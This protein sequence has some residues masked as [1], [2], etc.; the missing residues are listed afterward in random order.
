MKAAFLVACGPAVFLLAC[1]H[2]PDGR[3][4][5]AAASAPQ[6]G[7]S[8]FGFDK[9]QVGDLPAGW[10]AEATEQ[11]GALA[12]WGVIADATA[13]S[14][15]NV[16]SLTKTNHE[17]GST[18]NICWTD[19]VR[20]KDGRVEVSMKANSGQEDQGGG[21]IW[22]VQDR[23]NYYLCRA[24]PLENN[25]RL[26]YVKGGSRTQ[27]ATADARI[28]TGQWQRIAIEQHGERI[29]CFLNGQQLLEV[30]DDH[31]SGPGGVGVWTK[32][33]AA[34]SFDDITLVP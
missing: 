26:Y 32:A 27:I 6:V 23:D 24:N 9:E 30:T 5:A 7:R 20:F 31:I 11:Q 12:T 16:L 19:R 33:D 10:K 15:P 21:P 25:F 3:Q 22:R 14:K 29:A 2:Q 34:S 18:F 13:P 4:P 1:S 28:P 8:L 17:S